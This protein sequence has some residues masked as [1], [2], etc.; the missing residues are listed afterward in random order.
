MGR[1][2][3]QLN[4]LCKTVDKLTKISRKSIWVSASK[5]SNYLLKD[6]VVDWLNMYYAKY[7]LNT[8][9]KLRN[10][11]NTPTKNIV[12]HRTNT[13]LF[14]NGY[15]FESSVYDALR[16]KYGE[17]FVNLRGG[18]EEEDF[19]KTLESIES[20]IPIIAQASIKSDKLG[21]RGVVDLLVRSDYINKIV[22][23]P[24]L[25]EDDVNNSFY[26]VV[27]IKWSNMELCVDGKSVRNSGR[28]KAYKG[29]LLVYTAIMEEI[30][31][32]TFQRAYILSKSWNIDKKS[33]GYNCFE[34]LGVVDFSKQDRDYVIK[35]AHAIN[36]MRD[37]SENGG[38]WSPL[39]P[40]IK[41]M[42][43]NAC[44]QDEVWDSVKKEIIRE[45]KDITQVWMVTPEQRNTAFEKGI[46]KWDDSRCTTA[47]LGITGASTSEVITNILKA[48]KKSSKANI[49]LNKKIYWDS[50]G[51]EGDFFIDYETISEEYTELEGMNIYYNKPK[52]TFLF[53][54]GVGY[55]VNGE[56][57]YRNFTC[58]TI[59]DQE[60]KRVIE[61][62]RDFVGKH[63]NPRFFHWGHV[64]NTIL[65]EKINRHNI[66]WD[67]KSIE[68]VDVY[69]SLVD[70]RF[71]ING[72]LNFKL[73]E[74][75]AALYKHGHITTTWEGNGVGDGVSAMISA[76]NYYKKGWGDLRVIENYNMTDCKVLWEIAKIVQ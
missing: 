10:K 28:F 64:E 5:V 70:V 54:I 16:S 23:T 68:W 52:G 29:Q 14:K 39:Y 22:K 19:Q 15:L 66:N 30:Q 63:D 47:A 59:S 60:E 21:L 27:D 20:R 26:V 4:S 36:W 40:H 49:I 31:N 57:E 33:R 62:F 9:M 24:V 32:H 71:A 76:I 41:E 38:G 74:V 11:R 46:K 1:Y 6:P 25:D 12:K 13:P 8:S 48:N 2:T 75:A 72:A 67:I 61:S 55:I 37:L 43:C 51:K 44:N 42:C 18:I 58:D 7:G 35:T 56:F 34:R 50:F 73:K 17:E 3:F 53:M 69:K 45:T 65:A